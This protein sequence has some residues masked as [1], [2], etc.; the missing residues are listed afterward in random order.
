MQR[1]IDASGKT[2]VR[3]TQ[4]GL[5]QCRTALLI[6]MLF[7]ITTTRATNA[8]TH[9]KRCNAWTYQHVS[10]AQPNSDAIESFTHSDAYRPYQ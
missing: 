10:A 5:V 4:L 9:N 7:V 2:T 8:G 6:C 1:A 3:N